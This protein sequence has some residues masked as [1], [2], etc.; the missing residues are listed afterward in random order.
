[1]NLKRGGSYID[2]PI[3]IKIKK[4]TTNH[5]SRDDDKCFP[6]ATTLPLKHKEIEKKS[7]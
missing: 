5:F 7:G 1:M 2:S 4:A 3:W 6:Y